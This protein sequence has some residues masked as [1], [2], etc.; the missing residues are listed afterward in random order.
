ML[1]TQNPKDM[2][3]L[4]E[5]I[6]LANE[7]DQR[8]LEEEAG[9]LD[10]IIRMA[11]EEG[12]E[13]TDLSSGDDALNEDNLEF[14]LKTYN[15]D[16]EA[17]D[18]FFYGR[19]MA[20]EEFATS[21]YKDAV[22]YIKRRNDISD[23]LGMLHEP[24]LRFAANIKGTIRK[25][26]RDI[27]NEKSMQKEKRDPSELAFEKWQFEQKNPGHAIDSLGNEYRKFQEPEDE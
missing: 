1:R 24:F 27:L 7:L 21:W 14:Y 23:D 4:K 25:L 11:A 3:M 12:D 16:E 18:M 8:G 26:E 10:K 17:K 2:K 13:D 9:I 6:K 19:E 20:A 5:L 15:T 22:E